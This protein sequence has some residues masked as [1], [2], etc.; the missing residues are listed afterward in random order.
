MGE[1]ERRLL[2]DLA[3]TMVEL[4][5]NVRRE[6][7]RRQAAGQETTA[8]EQFLHGLEPL[9]EQAHDLV[10]ADIIRTVIERHGGG[11]YPAEELAA[12]AGVDAADTRRVLEQLVHARLATPPDAT[13]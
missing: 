2:A 6:R 10:I 9:A 7:D 5:A 1:A 11:P 3:T 8:L 12:I 13:P 4:V